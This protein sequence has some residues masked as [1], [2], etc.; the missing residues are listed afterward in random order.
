MAAIAGQA[1]ARGES[2]VL[3]LLFDAEHAV[4]VARRKSRSGLP[5]QASAHRS[6]RA[7]SR[8]P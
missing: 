1:Q 2:Y 3:C 7:V 4:Q 5:R 8:R 6:P